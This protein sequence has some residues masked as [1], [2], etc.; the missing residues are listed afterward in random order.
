MVWCFST[1]ASVATVLTTHPC[2]SRCLRVKILFDICINLMII[3]SALNVYYRCVASIYVDSAIVKS[4][5]ATTSFY[6]LNARDRRC[7]NL[8]GGPT[9]YGCFMFSVIFLYYIR[10]W[11]RRMERVTPVEGHRQL[12]DGFRF[13]SLFPAHR[14]QHLAVR[15]LVQSITNDV[16]RSTECRVNAC[17]AKVLTWPG[18]KKP[19]SKSNGQFKALNITL[20]MC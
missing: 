3:Y 17:C 1:R 4:D 10:G 6:Q 14:L 5:Q 16:A 9:N 19:G 2:V 18:R 15:Q 20:H 8:I 11:R 13:S 12:N 7:L